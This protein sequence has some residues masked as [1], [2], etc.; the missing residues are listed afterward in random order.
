MWV[1]SF[2]AYNWVNIYT[3]MTYHVEVHKLRHPQRGHAIRKGLYTICEIECV[4]AQRT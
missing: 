3:Q 2:C 1:N 4:R